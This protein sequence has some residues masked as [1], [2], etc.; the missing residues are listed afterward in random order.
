MARD[1]D[2]SF[3]QATDLGI[4]PSGA[5]ITRQGNVDFSDDSVDFYR[6][7]VATP[8]RFVAALTSRTSNANLILLDANGNILAGSSNPGT[9]LDVVSSDNLLPG[10]YF[11]EVRK[12]G[13]GST[14]YELGVHGSRIASAELN[15]TINR[16]TA[17]QRF[18]AKIP[19]LSSFKADFLSK[20][21]I[22]GKTQ[23][24][25]VFKKDADDVR[26]KALI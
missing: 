11:L 17:L 14:D 1:N 5:S 24:S 3:A 4:F 25:N 9:S 8:T 22:D 13:S 15:V 10:V 23:S 26:P 19:F 6:I 2:N 20:I 18:D 16:I 12:D 21:T 7:N